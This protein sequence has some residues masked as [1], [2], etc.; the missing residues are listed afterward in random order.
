MPETSTLGAF[1]EFA[2]QFI[3]E[4]SAADVREGGFSSGLVGCALATPDRGYL[5]QTQFHPLDLVVAEVFSW[6]SVSS[7]SAAE[8][9]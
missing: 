5:P 7:G 8:F 4:D 3:V 1:V 2:E 6:K 9:M